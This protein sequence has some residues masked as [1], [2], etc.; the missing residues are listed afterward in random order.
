MFKNKF[1][2]I[3]KNNSHRL[4]VLVLFISLQ[5]GDV[6]FAQE[7]SI[8]ISTMKISLWSEY[9]NSN[10][11]V[12]YKG[13]VSSNVILP[14]RIK[15]SI[16]PGIEP[17]V[18]SVTQTN[19]HI[20]DPFDIINEEGDTYVSFLLKERE[21][22]IEYYYKAFPPLGSNKS[23]IYNYK[24]YYPINS[25]SYEIQQPISATNF[26]TQPS[27]IR[28]VS[29]S[30]GILNHLVLTGSV[31]AGEIKTVNVSY[32]KSSKKTSLQLL[33]NPDGKWSTYNIISTIVLVILVG[34]LI[35]SYYKKSRRRG[36]GIQ[37]AGA[38]RVAQKVRIH[39]QTSKTPTEKLKYRSDRI[40][41]FCSSCGEKV[42]VGTNFCGSC[43]N[44]L[45]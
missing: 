19:E 44:Q 43:G 21:F 34:L 20:H 29:D 24:S 2:Q 45:D 32:F 31:A 7:R 12:M 11:L 33:E 6:A 14:V 38:K 42:E 40:P 30:K 1:S 39:N 36:S 3:I 16:I 18:A 26:I 22:A 8:D 35:K 27:S 17:H 23:F 41:R 13:R 15:F 9:D 10:L 28:T 5:Y 4:L 25:F 37:R